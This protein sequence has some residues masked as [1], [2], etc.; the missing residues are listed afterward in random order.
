MCDIDFTYNKVQHMFKK[1]FL[2]SPI[3]LYME[4]AYYNLFILLLLL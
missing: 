1:K 2:S 3:L 4:L